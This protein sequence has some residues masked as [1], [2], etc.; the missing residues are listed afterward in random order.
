[1]REV[2]GKSKIDSP[3]HRQSPDQRMTPRSCSSTFWMNTKP[4]CRWPPSSYQDVD[5]RKPWPQRFQ[6]VTNAKEIV[7]N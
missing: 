1:M 2:I 4:A 3:D 5:P 6:D 7:K